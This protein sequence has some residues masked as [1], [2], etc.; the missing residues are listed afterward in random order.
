AQFADFLR[1]EGLPDI[2]ADE[3]AILPGMEE[4]ASLAQIGRQ[5]RTGKYDC[6]VVDA[7]PTGETIRL[8]SMPESFQW[9]VGLMEGWRGRLGRLAGPFLRGTL[10]D[11]N[12][13]DAIHRLADRV[14]ELRQSLVDARRS[15]Y[16]LVVT[17]DRMVLKEARRAETYL[18]LFG[19]PI[20][21]VILNRVMEL[22]EPDSLHVRALM[23][24]QRR[25]VS[26]VRQTFASLPLL[27]APFAIDEPIGVEVLARLGQALFDHR[28]PTDV[29]HVGPTQMIERVG[30]GYLLRI[31]M[32][33]VDVGRL[34]LAKRGDELFVE[35]GNVR[36]EIAL[37]RALAALEPG[38]AR[39]REG[40]L[41]I[42]FNVM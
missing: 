12:V 33:N 31:P 11:L 22:D 14:K 17:P 3:L 28:D 9:Y 35:I 16:R 2:Q 39:L 36:R 7:A 30:R 8:L 6:I 10:P 1:R 38:Q 27:E 5:S 4:V 26:E 25:L 15:S 41:D 42:P 18:N 23:E 21:A 29:M 24:R 34:T 20:D 37:P 19:Y 13:V 40:M 32:P